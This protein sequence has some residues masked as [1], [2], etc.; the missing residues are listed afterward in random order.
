M[1]STVRKALIT[2]TMA[3]ALCGTVNAEVEDM[4]LFGSDKDGNVIEM[5]IKSKRFKKKVNEILTAYTAEAIPA[6]DRAVRSDKSFKL[7]EVDLGVSLAMGFEIPIV[8]DASVEPG[9]YV[10][11]GN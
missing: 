8:L 1:K 6:L 10:K 5:P 11:F 3:L 9:I 2:S 7:R 4:T